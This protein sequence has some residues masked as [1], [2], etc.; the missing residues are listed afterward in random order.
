MKEGQDSEY[1]VGAQPG[2]ENK[3]YVLYRRNKDYQFDE[4]VGVYSSKELANKGRESDIEYWR[5]QPDRMDQLPSKEDYEKYYK[6][7]EFTLDGDV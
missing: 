7:E 1:D 3:V 6:I 4:I 5:G 2:G